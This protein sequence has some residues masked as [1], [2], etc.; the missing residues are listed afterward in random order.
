MVI[1]ISGIDDTGEILRLYQIARDFQKIKGAVVWPEFDPELIKTEIEENRQWKL[2]VDNQIACV[3]ATTFTDP[4]IWEERNDDPSIYIHRIATDPVFRGQK[5]VEEIVRWS[6]KYAA[7][8]LKK[9]IRMDTIAGNQS[10]NNYYQKC[11]F[12][13]LGVLKLKE[14]ANLPA[15]YHEATVSLFEIKLV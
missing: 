6:R 15:H 5:M 3:W 4:E 9:F 8:N 2:V 12:K 10:L 11:G 13:F 7:K 1:E 14:T